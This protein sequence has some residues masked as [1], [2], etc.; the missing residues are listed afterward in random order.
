MESDKNVKCWTYDNC[1]HEK[2]SLCP[3]VDQKAGRSLCGGNVH[4]Q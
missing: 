2:D 4:G 1:D 3:A